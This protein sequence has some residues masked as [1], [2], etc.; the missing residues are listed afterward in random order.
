MNE[1]EICEGIAGMWHYHL[2]HPQQVKS[3][4]GATVMGTSIPLKSWG[5]KIPSYHIPES[6]CS[7]CD[8]IYRAEQN[9]KS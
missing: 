6:Y 2:R 5:R 1:I 3:L 4:C 7:N 8:E 9:E